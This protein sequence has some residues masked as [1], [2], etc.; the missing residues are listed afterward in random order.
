MTN[1]LL[2]DSP[3]SP[4]KPSPLSI[5]IVDDEPLI[6]WS[7]RQALR[8]RGHEVVTAG[9]GA[10]ALSAVNNEGSKPFGVVI[11]DYRLPDRQDFSLVEDVRRLL[12]DSILFMMTAFADDGMRT[13]A[14]QR[15]VRAVI[16]KPF[17][18]TSLV[19]LIESS[20][21]A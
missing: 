3:P 11:L 19:S 20:A 7:L 4:E 17:Q 13:E 5:L 2:R 6:L 9:T 21:Q 10:A 18:V 15:G 16:D 1:E 12:P 14:Q 8:A